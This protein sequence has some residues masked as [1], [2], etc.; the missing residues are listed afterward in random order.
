MVRTL[1]I[2]DEVAPDLT[3]DSLRDLSPELVLGAG[4]LPWDY[5]EWVCD[6]V[7]CPVA[8]VPGNHDPATELPRSE[9]GLAWAEEEPGPRGVLNL[10]RRVTT[11]AGLRV[12]GLGGCVRY[13]DGPHQ[14]TQRQFARAGRRM[15]RAAGQGAPVDVL[16]THAPPSGLGD[17]EDRP[18]V[19]IET[20][21]QLLGRLQPTWH[22]HGHIHPFGITQPDRTSGATTVCNVIPWRMFEI[23]PRTA[24]TK[25]TSRFSR[26]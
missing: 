7:T 18:H 24:A 11:V 21:H 9:T 20:L 22:F 4:D 13:N 6:T 25:A 3:A 26:M 12:A 23:E 17:R 2:A 16:L 15:M 19:G 14:Y 1:V 5:L 8:F 10:D